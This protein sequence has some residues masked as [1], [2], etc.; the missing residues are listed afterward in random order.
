MPAVR[1]ANARNPF[2]GLRDLLRP[3]VY[4][5]NNPI[6]RTGVVLTTSSATTLVLAYLFQLFGIVYN[7]YAG[8]IVFLFLPG[9]PRV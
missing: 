6:S 1:S 7:P 8:M 5:S 3:V 2:G 9:A 4:L